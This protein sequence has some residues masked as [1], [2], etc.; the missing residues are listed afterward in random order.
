MNDYLEKKKKRGLNIGQE[1][2]MV[3]DRNEWQK[4]VRECLGHSPGIEPQNLM[5][6]LSCRLSQLYEDL[7]GGDL[8]VA[9]PVI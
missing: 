7:G 5:K 2:R 9:K 4:F 3:Y 1:R 8:S 6:C